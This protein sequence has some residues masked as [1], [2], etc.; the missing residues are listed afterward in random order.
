MVVLPFLV[1]RMGMEDRLKR[2]VFGWGRLEGKVMWGVGCCKRATCLVT[3]LRYFIWRNAK[4][5]GVGHVTRYFGQDPWAIMRAFLLRSSIV[6]AGLRVTG[7]L[8]DQ[9]RMNIF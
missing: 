2:W 4:I 5:V 9:A 6:Y 3:R 1:V 8:V 7:D